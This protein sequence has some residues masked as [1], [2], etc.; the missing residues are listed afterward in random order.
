ME[1]LMHSNERKW[2]P[3]RRPAPWWAHILRWW[4]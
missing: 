4:L 2:Q 3:E 1:A